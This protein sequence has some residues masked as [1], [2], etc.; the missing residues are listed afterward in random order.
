MIE[1][2][3][4]FLALRF[5]KRRRYRAKNGL[6]AVSETHIIGNQIGDIG[7]GGLSFYYIDNGSRPRKDEYGL[8]LIS[9]NKQQKVHLSCK[10]VCDLEAGQMVSQNRRIKRRCVSFQ[11]L[12]RQQKQKLKNIIRDDTCGLY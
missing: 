4:R 5:R 1:R 10:T 8:T 7:M 2:I 6:Y 9:E 12:N 3:S 11:R